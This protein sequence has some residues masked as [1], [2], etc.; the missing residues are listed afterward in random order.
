MLMQIDG[1]FLFAA[2]SFLIFL[3]IIKFILFN[4][5]TKVLEERE[6]FYAKNTKMKNESNE[7]SKA[8]L[9]EKEIA[10][11]KSREEANEIIKEANLSAKLENEFQIKEA[12]K[13]AN[14]NLDEH[15]LKLNEQSA[16][17]KQEL[18]QEVSNFVSLMVS[19]ILKEEITV[20]VDE[21]KIKKHLKI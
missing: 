2:I 14:R 9:E 13:E 6:N 11:K 17:V 20:N 8:L 19:K 18:K 3:V 15:N 10:L 7:K 5:I 21:E 12:K 16:S 4:P 1:T